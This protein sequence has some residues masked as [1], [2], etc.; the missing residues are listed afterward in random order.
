V[1]V[2]P[3]AP[4]MGAEITGL[5]LGREFVEGRGFPA[6]LIA[7]LRAIWLDHQMIVIRGQNLP[8]A[9]QLDLARAFGVPDIYPFLEGLD[10]FPEITPV[11]KRETET[12]NF[13]GVWHTDTIYQDA[14][15]MATML[16]AIELPPIG[17]DTLFA[18]QQL[19]WQQL[20]DGMKDTLS[21]LRVICAA[22]KPKVAASRSARIAE[23]GK[24]VDA[25]AMLASHP[26]VRTHPETGRKGLYL[27]PG[28]A[29]RFDGW[30]EEESA[31]LL[32]F[33]FTHQIQPEFRCRL[34]WRVG[35]IA[36]WDNRSTLHYPLNDYHGHRRLLHRV[37]LKGDRPV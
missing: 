36:I 15:P 31:G 6:A 22:G 32:E 33:L 3:L 34:G 13:G 35:D 37:T 18:N 4:A 17:G 20:S 27:S 14:P 29:I 23:K 7:D 16:Q 12:V 24:Q 30:T 5:D 28:H 21:G 2:T 26:V 8:P 11:L 10:G 9:R 25:G 1:K 19:A